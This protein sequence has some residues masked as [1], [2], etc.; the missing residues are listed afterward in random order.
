MVH[1]TDTEVVVIVIA[2]TSVLRDCEI[3]IAFGHGAK[4]RY[5]PCH[6]IEAELGKDASVICL[7]HALSGFC[8]PAFH[9]VEKKTACAVWT[10]MP[11]LTEIFARLSSPQSYVSRHDLD[12]VRQHTTI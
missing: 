8:L 2:V 11:T 4:Q 1:V 12:S 3:W 10:S 5:I 7:C 9:E 6:I